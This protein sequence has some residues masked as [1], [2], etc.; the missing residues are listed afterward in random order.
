MQEGKKIVSYKIMDLNVF[1]RTIVGITDATTKAH[2]AR[3]VLESVAFSTR[4]VGIFFP[5]IFSNN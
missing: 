3:A 5:L 2:I 1:H 4:E